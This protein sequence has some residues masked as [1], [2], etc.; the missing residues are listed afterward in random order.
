MPAV[1][2]DV[3]IS[4]LRCGSS[5]PH[6]PLMTV[7]DMGCTHRCHRAD[8]RTFCSHTCLFQLRLLLGRIGSSGESSPFGGYS[9]CLH[10]VPFH[11]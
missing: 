10:S 2:P 11:V 4:M 6:C 5:M 1:W 7:S 9:A 3:Q 8:M